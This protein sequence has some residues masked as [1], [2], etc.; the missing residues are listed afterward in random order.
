M[1]L[2]P[3]SRQD[4]NKK[5][6][7]C[8]IKTL[9]SDFITQGPKVKEFEKKICNYTKG[10]YAV[11]T[12]SATSALHISCLA[13]G[14]KTNDIVWTVPNSFV[15]SSNCALLCG[16]KIDFVDIDSESYNLSISSLEKKLLKAKKEKK[17][18]KI[19]VVVH[20]AGNPCDMKEIYKFKKKYKFKIIEDASHALGSVYYGNKVGSC[21]YSDVTVF[22]FH[23]VKM[24]TTG[25]GGVAVTNQ[26]KLFNLMQLFRDH[27]IKRFIN[28]KKKWFYNQV[29]LG[30]NYRITD[31]QCAL[32]LSQ[33]TKLDSWVKKRN[34]LAKRY[35]KMLSNLPLVL[36]KIDGK[37]IS[38]FHLYVIKIDKA[39]TNIKRDF[40]F[41]HLRSK[42]IMVNIHYIPIYR[43]SFYKK[44]NFKKK[45]F[46]QCEEYYNS[47]ISIPLFTSLN[48]KNQNKIIK[49]I[50]SIFLS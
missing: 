50:K 4:I 31:I 46:P 17:I 8:V 41:N 36:P 30:L 35:S 34:Y 44:F 37:K 14:L 39:Q 10:R 49:E 47:A 29:L 1:K 21:I 20:L 23:P 38:S 3:Y 22:S 7:S 25:E 13:L 45:N 26:K 18:P 11:A 15:A 19:L 42:N 5:D 33:F 2:I 6:I 40:I 27:G 9:K 43:H 16:A 32:G 12:N 24:I 28:K 48:I